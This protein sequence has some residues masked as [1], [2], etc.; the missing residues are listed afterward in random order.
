MNQKIY[1]GSYI[2][3]L[4]ILAITFFFQVRAFSEKSWAQW[5]LLI[6]IGIVFGV[7]YFLNKNMKKE[8]WFIDIQKKKH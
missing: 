7:S 4:T 8:Q 6:I 3:L 2:L 5:Y 1:I